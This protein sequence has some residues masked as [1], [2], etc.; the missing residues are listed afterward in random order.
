MMIHP[1][2]FCMWG[3]ST[4][5]IQGSFVSFAIPHVLVLYRSPPLPAA[6]KNVT[7]W[8]AHLPPALCMFVLLVALGP[9]GGGDGGPNSGK[10]VPTIFHLLWKI[11]CAAKPLITSGVKLCTDKTGLACCLYYI[12]S[13]WRYSLLVIFLQRWC[14]IYTILQPMEARANTWR[15]L[16]N[17]AHQLK[18][19]KP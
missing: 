19:R 14:K 13:G 8:W 5:L 12:K 17:L 3:I 9:G 10:S 4:W 18:A 7:A 6:A 2:P 15:N 11:V 16:P 1:W